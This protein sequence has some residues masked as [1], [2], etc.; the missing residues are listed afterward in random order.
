ML[1]LDDHTFALLEMLAVGLELQQNDSIPADWNGFSEKNN[2]F[3]P[4]VR[5]LIKYISQSLAVGVRR[6]GSWERGVVDSLTG[7]DGTFNQG[8]LNPLIKDEILESK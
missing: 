1:E 8:M 3:T 2:D 6:P 4:A 5:E 7:W